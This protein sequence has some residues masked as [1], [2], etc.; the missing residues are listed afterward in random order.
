MTSQLL[1]AARELAPRIVSDR[2]TI[3]SHPEMAYEEEQTSTLVQAR[4]RDLGIPF[5]AGLAKTG[6]LAEIKGERGEGPCVL[7]RAD[8]DALPIE[9]KSGVPFASEIP[10]VMH[11]CGHDAHTAMLLGAA[12]LLNERRQAFAGTVKLMFQPAE[13]GGAGAA[14]MI[15]DGLL[16]G[17]TKVD[18]AFMLHVYAELEAGQVACGPGPL[19]AGSD[20]FT[21]TIEGRGGHAARPHQTVDPVV[22]GAQ[23]VTALQTLVAREVD[24][25][26]PAVV[27]LG[28]FN[29]GNR[30]NVISDRAVLTGTI[31]AFDD[32]LFEHLERRLREV[33]E[34]VSTTL[35][36][37]ASVEFEMRYPASVCD[38]AAAAHLGNSVRSLLGP[39]AVHK[40]IPR[41][42]AEDFAF[43]LQKVPGAMLWLGVKKPEWPEPKPVHTATFDIDESALP[44]GSSAMAGVALDYLATKG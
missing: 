22:V 35:R 29:A 8:M 19:L 42:G 27:T 25:V 44:V 28:S 18:A 24:P 37:R 43:V 30:H 31:R 16:D 3:H 6:V 26:M 9:E 23:V 40:A 5:R 39:D 21:I 4:L 13:E 12:Q 1:Q 32:T 33:V 36:A 15:E 17:P 2:R 38:P 14:R 11:A 20:S 41:M 7:L 10:G 34:G